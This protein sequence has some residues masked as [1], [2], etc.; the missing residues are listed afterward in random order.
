MDAT[1]EWMRPLVEKIMWAP[2][3][4]DFFLTDSRLVLSLYHKKALLFLRYEGM[5]EPMR[6]RPASLVSEIAQVLSGLLKNCKK[7]EEYRPL[8]ARKEMWL[9]MG[10]PNPDSMVEF[11]VINYT[12]T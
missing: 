8:K 10:T 9:I 4:C 6:P 11:R 5:C 3:V 1:L 7:K 12:A 2:A